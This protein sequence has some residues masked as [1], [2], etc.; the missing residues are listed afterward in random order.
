L[1]GTA[2]S[3]LDRRQLLKLFGALGAAGMAAPALAAC[4]SSDAGATDS[5]PVR[6]GLIVPQSGANKPIG[7]DLNAGF[8]LYLNLHNGQLGGH[9][10][11]LIVVDEGETADSGK[12]AVDKL[13]K[14]RAVHAM[15]GVASSTVMLAIRDQ[16]E[17]AQVP[18]LGSNASPSTLG[19]VKYIWRTSYVNDEAGRALGGYLGGS[20]RRGQSVYVIYDDSEQG[21]EQ[22]TGFLRT[23]NGLV[24]HP[25]TAGDPVQVQL[26]GNPNPSFGAY[27]NQI[28]G[29]GAKAVFA[30]FDGSAAAAFVRA[31]WAAKIPAPLYAPGFV[32]EGAPAMGAVGEAASGIYTAM[33]YAPDLDNGANRT[34]A[35]AYQQAYK[36]LPS[37]YAMASY[38]AASVLDK[39]LELAAGDLAPQS[40]NTA[41]SEIGQI[42][43]P[44]GSWQFNQTRT[45]LQR[46]YLRQVRREG[47]VM[48]NMLLGDLAMLG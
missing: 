31:Y 3:E 11:Q 33:N 6:I 4:T 32:T 40:I 9:P 21:R 5:S 44:R 45:P 47:G 35:S 39:A 2:V 37:T 17:S 42:D 19:S 24:G 22:G 7:D 29:S 8:Q 1:E 46:W 41:L 48:T 27:L 43:S 34:F 12:V 10:V 20:A 15:T 14:E 36:V 16:V 23:F 13:I 25:P 30:A 28:R 18:L 26:A 38:D